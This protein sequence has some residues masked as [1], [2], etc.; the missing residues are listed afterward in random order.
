M[1]ICKSVIITAMI[2]LGL[3]TLLVLSIGAVSAQSGYNPDFDVAEPWGQ[4]D[5]TDIQ[6]VA[7]NWN[8]YGEY[9]D[10]HNHW[11]ETWTGAG[12]GLFFNGNSALPLLRSNNA[13]SGAGLIGQSGAGNGVYGQS[14]S[15]NTDKAALYGYS[16]EHAS[17]VYGESVHGYGVY[18][19]GGDDTGDY[20]GYFVGHGGVYGEAEY[21]G[22]HGGHF[23]N[24][25]GIGVYGESG[26]TSAQRSYGVYGHAT[27]AS[28]DTSG[29]YG[30]SASS[31]GQG[32]AGK[33]MALRGNAVGVSGGAFAPNGAGGSFWNNGGGYALMASNSS[34]TTPTLY[35][36]NTGGAFTYPALQV[37]GTATFSMPT[38]WMVNTPVPLP[39][40][41]TITGA[42]TGAAAVLG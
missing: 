15:S 37:D 13:G 25:D 9:S 1:N 34:P 30:E 6:T 17:G 19:N 8:T 42:R 14:D 29:V 39:R 26:S 31:N 2:A 5:V 7:D 23:V 10:A 4:I 38:A 24:A 12:F 35:V 32:V 3:L 41:A 28:G 18:G 40:P 36:Q 20:G 27:A 33:A 16:S 21:S 11:G 22:E